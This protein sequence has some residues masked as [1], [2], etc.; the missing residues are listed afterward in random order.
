MNSYGEWG[1]GEGAPIGEGFSS[2]LAG[3]HLHEGFGAG[4][5]D[6]YATGEGK[7]D[8]VITGSDYGHGE[9]LGSHGFGRGL[10]CCEGGLE[11]PL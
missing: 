11:W 6:C 7:G 10:G 8:G 5:G 3:M 1:C 4:S 9:P 2:G